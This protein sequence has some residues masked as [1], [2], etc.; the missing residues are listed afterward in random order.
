MKKLI[1]L[2]LAAVMCLSLLPVMAFAAEAQLPP[3]TNPVVGKTYK[4]G[5]IQVNTGK[6]EYIDGGIN[7]DRFLTTTTDKASALDVLVE[8]AGDGYKLAVTIDGAKLYIA[9]S[10]NGEGKAC[11]AYTAQ[12]TVL[13]YD[14]T[15]NY[16]Y[17]PLDGTDYYIGSYQT[18]D[19]MS[20][21]KTSY[22]SVDK[23]GVSQFHAGLFEK[24]S[25]DE[26]V[27]KPEVQLPPVTNPV[28]GKAYK[29]GM[30]QVNT[31]KT[32]Y[33]D[34]GI[35]NDRFLTTTTDKASA[36]DVLVESAGDG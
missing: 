15:L 13:K 17:A 30:I 3:V 4:F 5:M 1:A 29:F 21:S 16:W 32:E 24:D 6:T 18:F 35:N 14:A 7:N 25:V 23:A 8:S 19:T 31:G 36:L 26:P 34:G 33:I 12:G 11:L 20:A 28:V 22:T 2:I 10:L 9:M 27:E